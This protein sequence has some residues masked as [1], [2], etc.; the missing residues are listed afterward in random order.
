MKRDSCS[1][2]LHCYSQMHKSKAGLKQYTLKR[3]N[4]ENNSIMKTLTASIAAI[5]FL[6]VMLIQTTAGARDLEAIKKDGVLRHLGV[7]YANFITVDGGLDAEL[8]KLFAEKIGVRYEFVETNWKNVIPDLIGKQ[9]K[10]DGDKV[11]MLA[12][13]PVKGDVI[14]TGLTVLPWRKQILDYSAPTFPNQ[15]WL[16]TA[17]QSSLHPIQPSGALQED[18]VQ[19]KSLLPGK[20]VFGVNG[21][22]LDLKLYN[23]NEA[24]AIG[25]IFEG[26]LNDLAPAVM[27]G[28]ADTSLLDVPDALV[29][30]N[31]WPGQ[32][33]IL[34]P[35]STKQDMAVGF[36]KDM[37]ELQKAFAAF[38]KEIL[39]NGTYRKML[40][41]Y[42]P[43]VPFYFP[44]F[45]A[46]SSG[47]TVR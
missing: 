24:K 41:K 47:V 16:V 30:L 12:D 7:P 8:M 43:D 13:V 10:V 21:T 28:S 44:E 46:E 19:T 33:K 5:S 29:A 36:R 3:E 39:A 31:K 4:K 45:L 17:N 42:Y 34:G 40:V 2:H 14:A 38:Y 18:I 15:V 6:L 27:N 1:W 35:I 20:T 23:L 25:K 26:S 32:I 37:P 11:E 22:C 9:I